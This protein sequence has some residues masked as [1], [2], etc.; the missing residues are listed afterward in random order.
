MCIYLFRINIYISS[1]CIKIEEVLDWNHS[2]THSTKTTKSYWKSKT[3]FLWLNTQ[4]DWEYY[5]LENNINLSMRLETI[6]LLEINDFTTP[7][8]EAGWYGTQ[9]TKKKLK[10]LNFPKE[11]RELT[12]EKCN[13][14]GKWHHRTSP[15][16]KTLLDRLPLKLKISN[17]CKFTS[18]SRNSLQ[19]VALESYK[20][21]KTTMTQVSPIKL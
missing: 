5:L 12:I 2:P 7:I 19:L 11:I 3:L 8:R 20:I 6:D 13:L 1:N 21:F 16:D 18:S 10:R 9:S 17:S 15:Y 4:T 14:R